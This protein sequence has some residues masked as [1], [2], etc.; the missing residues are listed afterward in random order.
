MLI[1]SI[2]VQTTKGQSVENFYGRLTGQVK[3]CSLEDEQIT[4]IHE[5]FFFNVIDYDSQKELLEENI[6][7]DTTLKNYSYVNGCTKSTENYSELEK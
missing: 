7:P 1:L 2:F 5:N 3:N 4:L 6:T